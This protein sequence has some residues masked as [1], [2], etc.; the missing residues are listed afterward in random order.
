MIFCL[1]KCKS[2]KCH[3][4]SFG[5]LVSVSEAVIRFTAVGFLPMITFVPRVVFC[6]FIGQ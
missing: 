5:E 3:W 6:E 4:F 2:V 1:N